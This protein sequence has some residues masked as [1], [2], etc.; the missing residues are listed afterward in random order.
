MLSIICKIH[1]EENMKKSVWSLLLVLVGCQISSRSALDGEGGRTAYNMAI[2]ATNSKQMLLN[3]VRLRY[4]DS[5]LF[6]DV[7]SVTTQSI[8]RSEINSTLPI[9]GFTEHNPFKVGGD[10]LW[11]D[12]PTI[13]YTPLEGP[14][15]A[16][17]MLR[18]IDL[19]T[20][21]LLVYSG[22]DVD[23]IF[24]MMIQNFEELTNC[25]ENTVPAPELLPNYHLFTEASDLLRMFQRRGELQM[26]V[27]VKEAKE[28]ESDEVSLQISFPAGSEQ[29]Q[30]LAKLI[31]C[32]QIMRGRFVKEI[33]L[34]FNPE[35]HIGIMPRSILSCMYHLSQGVIVPPQHVECG[36]VRAPVCWED[37]EHVEWKNLFCDLMTVHCSI[38]A[39]SQS[40]ISV[41]YRDFWFYIDDCDLASKRTFALLLQ[42]YNLNAIV[43]KNRGPILSLPVG[44]GG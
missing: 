22:W 20:I 3:L 39:P 23:R 36:M 33:L 38:R 41:K 32:T 26:G 14:S 35:G 37:D 16:A 29:G 17:R 11:E 5:P 30:R 27:K 6:L 25:P 43:P 15:F 18:P 34:G 8:F 28:N 13:T 10:L 2:Q 24:R 1:Y 4:A 40:F 9:P 31:H 21:Q 12:Q 44:L 19:R 42:L 7:S